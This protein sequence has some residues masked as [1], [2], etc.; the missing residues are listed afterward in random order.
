MPRVAV[1]GGGFS[2]LS[3]AWHLGQVGF[4]VTVL[5]ASPRFG[6][7]IETGTFSTGDRYERGAAEFY[8]ITGSPALKNLVHALELPTRPM[9]AS[10]YF[11]W[12]GTTLESKDGIRRA[13]GDRAVD[14]MDAFWKKGLE[15]RPVEEFAEAGHPRDNEHPW[16]KMSFE[17]VLKEHLSDDVGRDFTAF[18]GHSDLATSPRMTNGTFGFDNLLIDHPDYCKFYL[19]RDGNESLA[20]SLRGGNFEI[21]HGAHVNR[22]AQNGSGFQVSFNGGKTLNADVVV[23]TVWPGKLGQVEWSGKGLSEAVADHSRHCNYWTHYLRVTFL[24]KGRF[25]A[26]DFP[27]D[28]FVQ[29]CFGGA[30]VYDQSW[31]SE[32]RGVLSWL[33]AGEEAKTLSELSDNEIIRRVADSFPEA[34]KRKSHLG[35][36][37]RV[38]RYMSGVSRQPGGLPLQ[39]FEDRHLPCGDPKLLF[40]GDYLYD[41]TINGAY[42]SA[43]WVANAIAE[44]HGRKILRPPPAKVAASAPPQVHNDSL[45]FFARRV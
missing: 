19:L 43:L 21:L 44:P 33:L 38:D 20:K 22:I 31:L 7:R 14:A 41:A 11:V 17:K 9:R 37:A 16:S 23:V 28:Y 25:W 27:E 40:T 4:N 26:A 42:D 45:P 2:G 30:T 34:I 12:K 1:I 6:G 18:Q 8:D 5:E 13:L 10:P 36:E 32:T 24:F 3:T 39:S 15:H 35:M 29:D